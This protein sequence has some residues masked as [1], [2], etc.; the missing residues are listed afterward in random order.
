MSIIRRE[1][2]GE[3]AFPSA[4]ITRIFRRPL[5]VTML[6]MP[7]SNASSSSTPR[8]SSIPSDT[9]SSF[10][11]SLTDWTYHPEQK[12]GSKIARRGDHVIRQLV[13]AHHLADGVVDGGV[14]VAPGFD[15]EGNV[16]HHAEEPVAHVHAWVRQ[17]LTA[18]DRREN[19]QQYR[20]L[21]GAGG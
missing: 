12:V 15:A 11:V 3:N 2:A 14:R 4:S 10:R 19:A 21:D 18:I 17:K 9:W 13:D 5:A 6:L 7:F 16:L 20:N 8:L 1:S